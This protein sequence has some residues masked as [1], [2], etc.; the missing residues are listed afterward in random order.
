MQNDSPPVWVKTCNGR[1]DA[2]RSLSFGAYR[3]RQWLPGKQVNL[4]TSTHV[5]FVSMNLWRD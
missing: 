1:N 4:A 5:E 2:A 3:T